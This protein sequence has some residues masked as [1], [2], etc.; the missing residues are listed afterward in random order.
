MILLSGLCE[1]CREWV[2]VGGTLEPNVLDLSKKIYLTNS[3]VAR[4]MVISCEGRE[5]R[6]EERGEVEEK[7]ERRVKKGHQNCATTR[8]ASM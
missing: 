7:R 8:V 3:T 6:R 1:L 4:V 5:G 2:G